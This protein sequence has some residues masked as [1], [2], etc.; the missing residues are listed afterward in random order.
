MAALFQLARSRGLE[1]VRDRMFAG[2]AINNTERRAVL[3][4]A[5]RNR[6]NRP[7]TIGGRDVMADVHGALDHM[8][9]FS[10]IVRSGRWTGY[11]G[12]RITD[13]VNIGIGGSDL[14]PAMAAQALRR[15]C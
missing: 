14:G 6:S 7:M 12:M 2:D 10:V 15:W 9:V 3:H 5:L 1:S 13:V 11:T 4:V 8:R